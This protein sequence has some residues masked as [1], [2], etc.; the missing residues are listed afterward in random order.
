MWL[1]NFSLIQRLGIIVAL[2]T[3]LFV[4]LTAVVLN[5]HYS[6]L[7]SKSYEE[8]QHLVEVVHTMLGSFAARTDVSEEDAKQLALDA[9][10]ALR[11][12]GSNYFWI[13]DQTPS[14]V[15]HPIK[16]A[17]DGQDLRSFKDGNGKAF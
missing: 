16:P 9:V 12:D 17:L 8:N 10:K 5:Q 2:I 6:A 7:K 3:L 13:Q 14:M 11:Y 1:R 15:M 4:L